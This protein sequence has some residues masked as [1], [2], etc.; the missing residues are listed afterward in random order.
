MIKIPIISKWIEKRSTSTLSS[1]S[2]WFVD[3]ANGGSPSLSGVNVNETTALNNTAV[4]ACTRIISETVASLP[5][6]TYK[7]L[8]TGGKERAP[9]HPLYTLLH[10]EANENMT[11]YTFWETLMAHAVTWGNAFAWIEWDN[12]GRAKALWP[13]LPNQTTVERKMD[14]SIWYHT[15]IPRT[16]QTVALPAW[17]VLHVPGLGF[18]G[19]VGYSVIRM[20]REAV[21]LAIA[22][23]KYGASFFGNGARPGGVLEHPNNLSEDA[24]TRLRTSWNEMHQG[25]EKQHRVAILEEGLTYK[26]IGLPPEDSQFL[27]TRKFQVTEIAR[28]FRVPPH[29]VGDLERATFS[30]IEHQSIEFVVHTIRPW[31]IRIE[32]EVKRKL[33]STSQDKSFFAEFLVDGLLRG[34]AKTR[35]EALQ[36]Q[37]QNGIINA[38]EWREIENMNPQEGG[39][40]KKYLVN[41]A[42]IAVDQIGLTKPPEGGGDRNGQNGNKGNSDGTNGDQGN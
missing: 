19:L 23:E 31:L 9:N 8:K 35:N 15:T 25:L 40:G 14:G 22:T 39:Q 20:Q 4:F 16:G 28:M 29:M 10:E 11:S 7:R 6:I 30:N 18:D 2:Q 38:D 26:Q 36:I 33:L 13:L 3:W 17:R 1:P 27:E 34:D 41:S 37:R 12:F 21:G 5:F 24:Q 32:Q 42:M